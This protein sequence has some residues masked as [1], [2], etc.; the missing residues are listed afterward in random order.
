MISI[1][2]AKNQKE[3]KP[4][5]EKPIEEKPIEEKPIEENKYNIVC[6]HMCR[7]LSYGFR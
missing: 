1:V 6:E 5:E 7:L 3:E 4:I 2:V